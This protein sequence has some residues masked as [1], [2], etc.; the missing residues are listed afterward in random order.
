MKNFM[1]NFPIKIDVW[2]TCRCQEI[3]IYMAAQIKTSLQRKQY[4]FYIQ[5]L[6][7]GT[8]HFTFHFYIF[9]T[10]Y[11][12]QNTSQFHFLAKIVIHKISTLPSFTSTCKYFFY[13]TKTYSLEL[14]LAYS[15][16]TLYTNNSGCKWTL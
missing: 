2:P 7:I 6:H 13:T 8:N 16:C 1:E 11:K 3:L 15:Q 9:D 4:T 14:A 10:F 12:N 5:I